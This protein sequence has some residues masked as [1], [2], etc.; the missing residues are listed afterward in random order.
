MYIQKLFYTLGVNGNQYFLSLFG[1][2]LEWEE[3]IKIE[4]IPYVVC[5]IA[6]FATISDEKLKN[7]LNRF[8]KIIIFLIIFVIV[9]LIFTSLYIQWS[10]NDLLYIDGVQ[11]RYFLPI[12]PLILFLVGGLKIKS[13]YSNLAVTKLIC[14]SSIIIQLYTVT[15][16]LAEHL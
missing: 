6:A 5:G 12:L 16:I 3:N 15:A 13:S 1:G 4:I 10:D 11:G 14:I 2:Q 7:S 8:Q 9:L